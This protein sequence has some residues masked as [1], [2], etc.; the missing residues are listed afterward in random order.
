LPDFIAFSQY[1]T[2]KFRLKTE[3]KGKVLFTVES[4]MA[5][6]RGCE[7]DEF[8]LRV[9]ISLTEIENFY[10]VFLLPRF[11]LERAGLND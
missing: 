8:S 7:N 9:V 4:I 2:N 5:M 3:L 6:G 11:R 1:S 10:S